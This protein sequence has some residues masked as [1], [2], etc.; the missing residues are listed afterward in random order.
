LAKEEVFAVCCAL[1]EAERLLGALAPSVCAQAV[2]ARELLEAR[3]A[4]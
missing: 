2:S 4:G 1:A 3:L